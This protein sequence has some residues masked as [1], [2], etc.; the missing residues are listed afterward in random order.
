M[1]NNILAVFFLLTSATCFAQTEI[2][3]WD[4]ARIG[5]TEKFFPAYGE[6]FLYPEFSKHMKSLEGKKVAITGYFLNIDPSGKLFILSKNPMASCFFCGMG[7]PETAM[8]LQFKSKP[9]FN[10]DDILYVTGT[11]KLN[12]D[13]VQHFNYI[14]TDCV[15]QKM[16]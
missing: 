16:N 9:D 3:W 5:Y 10:T 1:K 15:A 8:E 14:L 6:H 2:N 13:D 12:A 7:G 4:L 11:L